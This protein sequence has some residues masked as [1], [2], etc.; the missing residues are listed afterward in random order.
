M[1]RI[2]QPIQPAIW[3][4]A[5][6]CVWL[7]ALGRVQARPQA[8]GEYFAAA[9]KIPQ[10]Q[11]PSTGD[12]QPAPDRAT[13]V[14]ETTC[15]NCHDDKKQGYFNSPHHRAIDPRTPAAKQGCESCHGA[16]SLHVTDPVANP[17]KRFSKLPPDQV[18]ETCA[19]CHNR[20]EHALWDGSQHEN[21]GL[22]CVSCHSVHA[23][24]NEFRS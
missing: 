18:N 24:K 3:L 1:R 17:V 5:A 6:A 7:I 2:P 23:P 16:G 8:A 21:R 10:A 15:L 9:Q 4:V 14:G 13:Y 19:S 12:A 22:S 20:G 11:N